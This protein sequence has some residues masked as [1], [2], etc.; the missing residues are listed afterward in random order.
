MAIILA[1]KCAAITF[2]IDFGGNFR[3]LRPSTRFPGQWWLSRLDSLTEL[4]TG[5]HL[6]KQEDGRAQKRVKGGSMA[7]SGDPWDELY[8]RYS[9]EG[10]GRGKRAANWPST[11]VSTLR[12]QVRLLNQDITLKV[13]QAS[14]NWPISHT[15]DSQPIVYHRDIKTE[16]E[17]H[18]PTR[19]ES[20]ELGAWSLELENYVK[21]FDHQVVGIRASL[22]WKEHQT[23]FHTLARMA[24]DVFSIP[25]MS[26]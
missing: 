25:A 11:L 12:L 10:V 9:G 7:H 18:A 19:P 5:S 15:M 8:V 16:A 2:I 22:K 14:Q 1:I 21:S 24:F 6:G 13:S 23:E 17:G 26:T 4:D 20:L 3:C